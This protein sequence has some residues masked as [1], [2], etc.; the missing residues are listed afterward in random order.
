MAAALA[1]ATAWSGGLQA[2]VELP[3]D[4]DSRRGAAIA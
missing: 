3:A 2:D 4:Y 1:E